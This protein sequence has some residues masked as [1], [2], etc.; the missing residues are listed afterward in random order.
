MRLLTLSLSASVL[1]AL[2]PLASADIEVDFAWVQ[3]A[4]G[5][6]FALMHTDLDTTSGELSVWGDYQGLEGDLVT[7]EV[8]DHLGAVIGVLDFTGAREGFAFGSIP[9][10]PS[11]VTERI[12]GGY[13]VVFLTMA[14]PAGEMDGL[15]GFDSS[16]S[17]ARALDGQ[18]VTG[19]VGA[20][21]ATASMN[22][23]R[24]RGGRI[25]LSGATS[26]LDLPFTGLELRGP[27]WRG[28]NGP[29][30]LDLTPF[31]ASHD[32]S[33]FFVDI[34]AGTLTTEQ[35]QDLKE[36]FHYVL[37]STAAFPEGALRGQTTN[38]VFSESFCAPRSSATSQIGGQL[39]L[40]GS[41]RLIDASLELRGQFFTQG[42]FV[43]PL[44]GRGTGHIFLPAQSRGVLCLGGAHIARLNAQITQGQALSSFSVPIRL[45]SLP[46]AAPVLPGDLLHFQCWYR[47]TENGLPTSNFSSAVRMRAR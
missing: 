25:F 38:E 22:V 4:A 45:R 33:Q 36:G 40:H 35:L 13:S 29:L 31:N 17:R 14:H 8:R 27:A 7:V 43:L 1:L 34:P 24:V 41:P 30:V 39:S 2:N 23:T 18:Q 28:E 16:V 21:N 46:T 6:N 15:F 32:P 47:D 12:N 11:S 5:L 37:L 44:V 26:G 9:Q 10:A 3:G 42:T 20:L 19:S